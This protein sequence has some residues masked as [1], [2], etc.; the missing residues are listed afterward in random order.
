[1]PGV[2]NQHFVPRF[3]LSSF[4]DDSGYLGVVRHDADGLK[5]VFRTRPDRPGM[6]A[7]IND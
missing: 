6:I 1:M 5:P 7:P 3:Y 4:T 2:K